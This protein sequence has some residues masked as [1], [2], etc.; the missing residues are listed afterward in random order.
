MKVQ[1]SL[2]Q[3]SDVTSRIMSIY[4]SQNSSPGSSPG[5]SPHV[6]TT[7]FPSHPS[8]YVP[9]VVDSSNPFGGSSSAYSAPTSYHSA[10]PFSLSGSPQR[11]APTASPTASAGLG[12]GDDAGHSQPDSNPFAVHD[13]V[14]PAVPAV[15]V[16]TQTSASLAFNG[17]S[18]SFEVL[19]WATISPDV[20]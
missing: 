9:P 14:V 12:W 10:D 13:A 18:S 17:I 1:H 8:G 16:H 5:G 3:A 19:S 15:P 2:K 6:N 11:H 20:Y 7:F 4:S